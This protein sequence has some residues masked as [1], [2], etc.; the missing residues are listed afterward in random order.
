MFLTTLKINAKNSLIESSILIVN[1]ESCLHN[2]SSSYADKWWNQTL[3]KLKCKCR[4]ANRLSSKLDTRL[5]IFKTTLLLK[6]GIVMPP[7]N[8][9]SG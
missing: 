1:L 8:N 4:L 3:N 2:L 6:I 5:L 9:T 7:Q